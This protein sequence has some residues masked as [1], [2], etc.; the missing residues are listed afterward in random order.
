MDLQKT[1]QMAKKLI[2]EHCPE[3]TFKF[4]NAKLRF[5]C[6][7][8][9]KKF[10]SLSRYL[11]IMND[12]EKVRDTI[13]HEIAHA[14]TRWHGH[15]I[16]WRSI[17]ISLGCDGNRCYDGKIVNHVKGKYVYQCPACKKQMF[18]HRL[19]RRKVACGSCCKNFNNNK[20]SN[21]YVLIYLG[22]DK[23]LQG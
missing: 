20:F 9:K 16:K 11:V 8:Y 15:N 5:G 13:L 17:A 4:D 12:E 21:D 22:I 14:L 7:N 19:K 3:F 2:A 10:I 18:Y 23:N 6:C 1:K